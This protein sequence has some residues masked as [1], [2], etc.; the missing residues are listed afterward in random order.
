VVATEIADTGPF[1]VVVVDFEEVVLV[2]LGDVDVEVEMV[3]DFVDV[4]WVVEAVDVD[5]VEVDVVELLLEDELVL[6]AMYVL[7]LKVSV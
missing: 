4:V 7:P 6:D 1:E 5:V 3:L 2:V